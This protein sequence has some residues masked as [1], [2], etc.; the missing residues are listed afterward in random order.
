MNH[1]GTFVIE[2]NISLNN[3]EHEEDF[4]SRIIKVES[5]DKF[6]EE[7]KTGNYINRKAYIGGMYGCSIPKHSKT[8]ILQEDE[9]HM[10]A[11][12]TNYCGIKTKKLMYLVR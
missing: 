5:W 8:E 3:F 1:D 10:M 6:K 12:V 9:F 11:I 4:Q 7:I 2:T